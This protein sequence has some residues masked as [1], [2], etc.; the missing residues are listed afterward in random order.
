MRR[1]EFVTLL[2]RAAAAWFTAADGSAAILVDF[3]PVSSTSV[4][5]R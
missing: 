4:L 3:M 1:R 5:R 2:G